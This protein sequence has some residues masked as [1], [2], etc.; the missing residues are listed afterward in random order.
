MDVSDIVQYLYCPRKLYFL[1][2]AGIRI[3]KPKMEEGKAAQGEGKA[4]ELCQKVE[5]RAFNVGLS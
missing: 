4:E 2:I 5:R 1:K 3:S